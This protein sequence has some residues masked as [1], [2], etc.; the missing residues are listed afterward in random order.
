MKDAGLNP[1]PVVHRLDGPGSLERYLLDREPYIALAPHGA[2]QRALNWLDRCFA[3]IKQASYQV[4]V[5]GLAVTNSIQMT[6]FRWASVDSSTWVQQAGRG[7]VLVPV[8]GVDDRPDYRHRPKRYCVTDRMHV[9]KNHID[10]LDDFTLDDLRYFIHHVCELS[11]TEVRYSHFARWRALIKYFRGLE[12]ASG[13]H[14]YFVSDLDA[15]MRNALIKC[16]A[17]T[18]LLS[19]FKLRKQRDGMLERY[20]EGTLSLPKPRRVAPD[21]NSDKYRRHR[22]LAAFFRLRSYDDAQ[23]PF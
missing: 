3:T 19:F 15:Q 17:K 8:F 21:Y 6:E 1:M 4:Q 2:G 12:A 14:L 23:R 16:G 13:A 20:V 11:L 22:A 9:E 5:H 10:K 7:N 18:H